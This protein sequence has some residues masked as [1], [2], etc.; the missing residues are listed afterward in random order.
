MNT[1]QPRTKIGTH[2]LEKL[3]DHYRKYLFEEYLP[4][5]DEH[6]IDAERG[7]FT[8]VLDHDGTLLSTDK[9]M[10]Y[11]G[12]GLWVYS[13]LYE[14]FGKEQHLEVARKTRDFLVRHGRDEN[15]DWVQSLDREGNV[16][17]P[18]TRRGYAG[19]FVAEGLQAYA[20]VSGDQEA[21]E[22]AVESL[23]RSLAMFDDPQRNIDEG[24][25]PV[26][27][28]GLRTLGQHMVLIL[29]LSQML[30]IFSDPRLEALADRVLE[31]IVE[32][33]WNPEYRLTNEGL[34]RDYGRPDDENEDFVY[35]GHGIE[36]LWMTL[37]EAMRRKDR[38]LF[39]LIAERFRRHVEVA[40]DD[41]YGGVFRAMKVHGAFTFDKVL[42]AQ[43]EVLI[44][45]MILVEHTDWEWPAVWFGRMF[46]YVEEKF[47]LKQYGYPLYLNG[48]DRKVTF[49]PHVQRKENYH[50]PRQ[51]MRNLLA[52][53]RMI[54][55]RGRGAEFWG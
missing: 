51:V 11:Q 20:R 1:A 50:H 31:A 15:G 55:R 54:E 23:W 25:L 43:E 6:G 34:D 26:S 19:L 37:V 35:L 42:W 38:E 46:D 44:G 29:I 28:P 24:Y 21:L 17:S 4:F 41:V 5:W 18:A 36:T 39:E 32:R 53:E 12:R 30:E 22:L 14:Q 47:S 27:Y 52:L 33:F 16:V 7:G 48:G 10:W 3:R 40:W 2:D 45:C 13:Y 49:T 9:Y 8:C